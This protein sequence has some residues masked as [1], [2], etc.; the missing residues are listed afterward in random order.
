MMLLASNL[1]LG[2]AL[3]AALAALGWWQRHALTEMTRARQRAWRVIAWMAWAATGALVLWGTLADNWRKMLGEALDVREQYLSE[4]AVREPVPHD[5]RLVTFALLALT[6]LALGLLFARYVGGYPLQLALFVVGATA[7]FPLYLV[8]QRLD[9]GLAGVAELPRL[10]SP[11]LIAT[12]VYL[13]LDYSANIALL[14]TTF[15][16]LLGLTALPITLVLDL[17]GR[18]DPP[19]EATPEATAFYAELHSQVE[20]R[21][22]AATAG[23]TAGGREDAET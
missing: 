22:A 11:A 9:T 8:R 6:L 20:A 17:L 14:L 4:R 15:A 10:F 23:H 7:F 16:G 5:I 19:F 21:R 18:R 12:L 2:L 13:L 1:A 3:I